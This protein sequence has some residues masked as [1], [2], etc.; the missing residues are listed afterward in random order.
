MALEARAAAGQG[1]QYAAAQ[2]REFDV[3]LRAPVFAGPI[4]AREFIRID[5]ARNHRDAR[6]IKPRI[7]LQHIVAQ[8]AR[9]A[10]HTLATGHDRAVAAG[11]IESMYRG[12]EMRLRRLKST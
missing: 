5:S 9:Y 8:R 2:L 6:W 12:D 7:V 10:D 3:E 11:R 1:Q 4:S